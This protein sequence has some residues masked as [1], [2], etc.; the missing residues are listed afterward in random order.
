MGAVIMQQNQPVAYFSR[1]LN[2][3]QCNYSTIEKELL[4]IVEVFREFRTMLYGCDITVFT[5]HKNLTY[6]HFN[7]Q[8][9]L[10]WRLYIE[11]FG[12]RFSYVRGD[13]NNIADFLSRVPISEGKEPPGPYG[14]TH[15]K[16]EMDTTESWF[17][18]GK[19]TYNCD[20]SSNSFYST[21]FDDGVYRDCFSTEVTLDNLLNEGEQLVNPINYQHIREAQQREQ[22]LWG[23]PTIDP[24]RYMYQEFGNVEVVCYRPRREHNFVIMLPEAMVKRTVQ[25]YHQQLQHIGEENLYQTISKNFYHP[26]LRSEV[27]LRVQNCEVCQRN[28]QQG[29]GYGHLAPREALVAPWFEL[30]IDTIGPWELKVANNEDQGEEYR[31]FYALT[32]I[33]TVT[34]WVEIQRV[35]TTSANDAATALETG[36]LFRYP[37]PMRIVHDQ[38]TEFM[39]DQFQRI[40]RQWGIRNAPISVRNPQ[41]NAVCERMHQVVGNV[42][43]TLSHTNQPRNQGAA[44]NMVDY[45][46]QTAAYALRATIKRTTGVSPGAVIFHRDMLHD[47]PFVADLLL[48][49]DKKQALIDYN[50]RRENQK[51]RTFDYQPGQQ[52]LE[53][54]PDP[55]KLGRLTAGPFPIERV[56][57]NGTVTIRRS[58]NVVDRVNIRRIRPFFQADRE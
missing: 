53:I 20:I 23:L 31:K 19:L 41:A 49:K 46:L 30:A 14:P 24:V 11:E 45:A 2:P 52:V 58:P 38:G 29:R 32:M 47:L 1:K 21:A 50:L 3:A 6:S 44:E 27:R 5:D 9:V 51:R 56:H 57:C 12:P 36:W 43:R 33:D 16:H 37:R 55:K 8:R 18:G 25:W 26:N 42:L 17:V 4:S 13:D 54:L 35:D 39:G 15:T 34:G 40:L 28:K 10:R 48:L 7:T 22:A